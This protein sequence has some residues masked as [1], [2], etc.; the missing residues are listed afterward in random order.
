MVSFYV[1]VYFISFYT[2]SL[3]FLSC[4]KRKKKRFVLLSS[5]TYLGLFEHLLFVCNS[6]TKSYGPPTFFK[7]CVILAVFDIIAYI[8]HLT[9]PLSPVPTFHEL[10]WGGR[11]KRW[12]INCMDAN[13]KRTQ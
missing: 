8:S 1:Y 11:N 10:S 5:E 4:R 9:T 2:F 6:R 7:N 12:G 13:Y 3:F